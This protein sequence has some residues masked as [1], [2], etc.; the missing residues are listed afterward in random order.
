MDIAPEALEQQ[1]KFY[2]DLYAVGYM[3]GFDYDVYERCR[4]Y[5]V[6]KLLAAIP[7]PKKILD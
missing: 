5:T 1:K 7:P 4:L 6:R 3:E 2:D